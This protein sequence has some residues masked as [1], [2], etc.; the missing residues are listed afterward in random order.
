MKSDSQLHTAGTKVCDSDLYL[1]AANFD[2]SFLTTCSFY[3]HI[4]HLWK[5]E[6]I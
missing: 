1:E 3:D 5:W 4:L 2:I 6:N